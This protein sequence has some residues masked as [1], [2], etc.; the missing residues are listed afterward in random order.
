ML[1]LPNL[2][3]SS[4]AISK[5]VHSN[6]FAEDSCAS[7]GRQAASPMTA[8]NIEFVAKPREAPRVQSALA[9]AI[10]RAFAGVA[11]Y[12]GHFVFVADYEARLVTVVTLWTGEDRAQR[13]QQNLRWVRALL[14]PFLDRC[15]RV[16]TLTALLAEPEESVEEFAAADA[17]A[18]RIGTVRSTEEE[19][20]YAA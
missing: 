16:Q 19:V 12:A 13:C 11:G 2:H 14:E 15:L 1:R 8:L 3:R 9:T 7:R 4:I 17:E 6:D 5:R 20:I 18:E 10:S